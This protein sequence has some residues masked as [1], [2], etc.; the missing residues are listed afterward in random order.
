[1]KYLLTFLL[2]LSFIIGTADAQKWVSTQVQNKNAVLEEFTGIH[3][4]Y[5]PDGHRIANDIAEANPG[6]VFLINIH[7][8]GYATPQ[9]GEPD[10][11]TTEGTAIDAAAK[12]AGYPAGSVNRTTSPWS[13]DRGKWNNAVNNILSQTSPVNVAVRSSV[14]F[15]TR[16]LTVEVEYYY[17]ANS[18]QNQNYLTVFLTQDNIQGYQSDYGNYNPTNWT[19]DKKY[20]HNHA[21]RLAITSGGAFGEV[22]DTTTKDH[23]G[24]KKF[25]TVLPASLNQLNFKLWNLNVV[26]FISESQSNIYSADGGKVSFDPSFKIDLSEKNLTQIGAGYGLTQINPKVEVTN[27]SG[28]VI[29]SFDVSFVLNGS[30]TKKSFSGSLDKDAKTVIDWGSIPINGTGTY[31]YFI[32]GC[33]NINGGSDEDMDFSNDSYSFTGIRF[34]AKAFSN[35]LGGFNSAAMPANTAFDNSKNRGMA[36]LATAPACGANNTFGAIRFPLHVSWG[37][38][39]LPGYILFGES[40]L[41]KIAQPEFSYYYAYS[42]DNFGGTAPTITVEVSDDFGANW[43]N[44]NTTTCVQTGKPAT[45][46]NWYIPASSDYKKIAISLDAYKNKSVVFRVTGIPGTNGNAMYIDE[47]SVDEATENGVK[48][49]IE[50]LYSIIYPNPATTEIKLND[51]T[52]FGKDYSIFSVIGEMVASGINTSNVINIANLAKGSYY[53]KINNQ[54]FSFVK[55]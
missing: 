12:V 25:E 55:N 14:D 35:Y 9:A 54:V 48:Q 20:R 27:N 34:N 42:D 5:C 36:I 45:S 22:I 11:R 7:A 30:E 18:P 41:S 6:R 38:G 31:S 3:C 50:Q 8:G 49:D 24:Y 52:Y 10:L 16:K 43:T 47:I 37:L 33:T 39:G 21:L 19:Y 44:V 53:V 15:T 32:T 17:T 2:C 28:K 40:D 4:G 26:A 46:G 23:Y 29:T 1:M 51:V 13:M